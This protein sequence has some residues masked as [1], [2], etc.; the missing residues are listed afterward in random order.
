MNTH[1]QVAHLVFGPTAAGKST[2]ART[3][4]AETNGV[5]FAIDEW[6]LALF[7]SDAPDSMDLAWIMPRVAR[8]QAQIW[9]V[10]EQIL[11]TGTAVVLELGLLQKLERAAIKTKVE[12]AGYTAVFHFIDADLETRRQRV[13]RRNVEKGASY[14]FD[15]TPAMFSAMEGYFERPSEDELLALEIR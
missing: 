3:L 6:M 4:A 8:C 10:A 9:S 2:F 7:A 5:R 13:L 12:K 1:Q 11:G 15:V 14:S